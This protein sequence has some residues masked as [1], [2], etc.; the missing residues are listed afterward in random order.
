M[1]FSRST[2]IVLAADGPLIG[3][4]TR[5]VSSRDETERAWAGTVVTGQELEGIVR[6]GSLM[7]A[8]QRLRPMWLV[9]RGRTPYVS[10]DGAP[11]T[12]LSFLATIPAST[13]REVRL[14]RSSSG[15]GRAAVA[16]NGGV[17]VGDMIIVTSRRGKS[18]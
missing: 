2:L 16:P 7:E 8:L 15:A 11:P 3:C 13:I 5:A 6:Q 12:D 1:V 10:V 14:E 4:A 9:S 18:G 17:I